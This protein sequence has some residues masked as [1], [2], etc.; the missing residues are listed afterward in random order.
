M[1]RLISPGGKVVFF[2]TCAR[3]GSV[4]VVLPPGPETAKSE[5]AVVATVDAAEGLL[6]ETGGDNEDA[7][8]PP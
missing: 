8:L 6:S 2:V 1:R 5:V 3:M 7:L 4:V